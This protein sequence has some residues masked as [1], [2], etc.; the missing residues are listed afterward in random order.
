MKRLVTFFL[1]AASLLAPAA[2]FAHGV[3][4]LDLTGRTGVRTLRFVYSTG[5]PMLF[6]R[7]KL[8]PPSTPEATAQETMSDREGY[9]S[10]VPLEDGPWRIS[11]EDGMGH[12]GEISLTVETG[13]ALPGSA[14]PGSAPA[15]G[16]TAG[17]VPKGPP[18]P[19]AALLGLS[20][21]FNLFGLWYA[22]KKRFPRR[23][24]AHAH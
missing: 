10:F 5:E 23:E 14:V 11:V 13:A 22:L 2:A 3:D 16:D 24:A 8:Y 1:A 9:F 18:G 12:R 20:L 17:G 6:A 21:I 15:A 19:L 4:I 7:V